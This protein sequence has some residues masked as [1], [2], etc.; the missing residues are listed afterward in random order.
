LAPKALIVLGRTGQRAKLPAKQRLQPLERGNGA[1]KDP[2]YRLKQLQ[3]RHYRCAI[4]KK[5]NGKA[6]N[7]SR[8]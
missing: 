2:H 1:G 5:A 6:N 7:F 8:P 3:L 4:L